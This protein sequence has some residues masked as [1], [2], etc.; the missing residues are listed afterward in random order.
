MKKNFLNKSLSFTRHIFILL[1][2]LGIS[3]F[4]N[5]QDI[6]LDA[7]DPAPVNLQD[8]IAGVPVSGIPTINAVH[9]SGGAITI[10]VQTV[11][12]IS[13]FVLNICNAPSCPNPVVIN[14]ININVSGATVTIDGTPD[15]SLAGVTL[16]F[17]LRAADG[18]N[19]DCERTY[20]FN[21]TRKPIDL[22]LVL[23]KSGSM[24]A[25]VTGGINTRWIALKNGVDEFLANYQPQLLTV[26]GA[27]GDQMGIRMFSSTDA[28]PVN[29]PFN[30]PNFIPVTPLTI[31]ASILDGDAPGGSTAMGSGLLTASDFLFPGG[32]DNGH[33]KAILLFTDGQQNVPPDVVA[34]PGSNPTVSGTDL[35]HGDQIQIHTIGLGI[36]G[37][38]TQ[39][40]YN[41][42]HESGV[43]PNLGISNIAD[44]SAATPPDLNLSSYLTN[45]SNQLLSGSTPQYVDVRRNQFKLLGSSF[46]AEETFT[47]S[48]NIDKIF[49][50]FISSITNEARVS[51]IEKDGQTLNLFDSSYIKLKRGRGWQTFIISVS[52]IKKKIPAF[53]SDGN[54]KITV[55]TGTQSAAPYILSL[56]A[57]DHN[58]EMRGS[59]TQTKELVVGDALPLSI[60]FT[61][62][63][64][65]ITNATA[66]AVIAKPGDDLGDL[67]ART[68]AN[69]QVDTSADA[70]NPGTQ[71]L[72]EL[73][74]DSN[75]V[76]RLLDSNHVVNLTYD[77]A[78]NKYVGEFKQLDV[79]GVYQ[80]AYIVS[81]NDT[82]LG[83]INR[84]AEESVY[85]RFP[86]V[87]LDSSAINLTATQTGGTLVFRP[88]GINGKFIG[89]GWGNAIKIEGANTKITNIVDNLD[90]SY[91]ITIQG[92][93]TDNVSVSIGTAE[94]YKGKL[95]DIGK[96]SGG[97]GSDIWK[98]WWF[99]LI[100][101]VV[102]L[103]IILLIT[104]KKKSP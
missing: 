84:Y 65:P 91:T 36:A 27:D 58:S 46:G 73:L 33:K 82:S 75:F 86:E 96:S 100:V 87:N 59:T 20:T 104:R 35:T 68:N 57:D 28:A 47:V 80:V 67:L 50:N 78:Q 41:I 14:G 2:F 81:A 17:T 32:A 66:M 12:I 24:N 60:D 71:K 94:I 11:D 25:I 1:I 54:W 19:P 48:K 102:I 74:K 93:L 16:S 90:G 103:I 51:G 26:G 43:A 7:C 34:V 85:I 21:I 72:M 69:I 63:G 70:D 9:A 29:A 92:S 10:T 30:V 97:T 89:P 76:K 38:A 42:A 61:K 31:L 15:A 18:T 95:E 13:P 83:E 56:T 40:L 99:W 79:S 23:D 4:L 101:I 6:D 37:A 77:A 39:T 8:Q 22:M 5:A 98:Q 55:L 49:I 64:K 53:T 88:V 45:I 52:G 3:G 44:N 62:F